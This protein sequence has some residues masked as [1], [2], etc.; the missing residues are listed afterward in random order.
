MFITLALGAI[1]MSGCESRPPGM[2]RLYPASITVIQDDKPLEGA[3]VQLIPENEANASWGPTGISDA[4]GVVVLQ[5]NGR[6]KGAPLGKYKVVVFKREREQHP[7]PE[8]AAAPNGDPNYSKYMAIEGQLKTFD[9]IETQYGSV[10]ETPLSIEVTADQEV[11]TV[12]VGKKFTT[13]TQTLR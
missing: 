10:D 5:T 9:Y 3:M 2:P 6:Y 12:D 8:W 1:S 13:E 7:H 4:L 11:Y